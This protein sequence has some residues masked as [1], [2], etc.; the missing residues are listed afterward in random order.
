MKKLP[1][2]LAVVVAFASVGQAIAVSNV[3]LSVKGSITPAACEPIL[4]KDGVVDHGKISITDLNPQPHLS[5]ILPKAT[6]ELKVNCAGPTLVA[7][8]SRDNRAGSSP[9]ADN[10]TQN[11][12]LGFVNGDKEDE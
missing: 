8:K 11:F 3:D 4:S 5:T 7:I 9:E 2:L 6:L 1:G 10:F 12:G